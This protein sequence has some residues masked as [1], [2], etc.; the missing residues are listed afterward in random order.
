MLILKH[1]KTMIDKL[2]NKVSLIEIKVLS[3]QFIN[4]TMLDPYKNQ[5]LPIEQMQTHNIEYNRPP[6]QN[7]KSR[8]IEYNRLPT[9]TYNMQPNQSRE[10]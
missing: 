2:M 4:V 8:E 10:I 9:L 7:E 1:N 3:H 6:I 5:H